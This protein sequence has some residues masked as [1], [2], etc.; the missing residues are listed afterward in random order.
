[1][2]LQVSYPCLIFSEESTRSEIVARGG[3]N[4]AQSPQADYTEQIFLP[5]LRDRF[6]LETE[7]TIRKHGYYPRG[8]GEVCLRIPPIRGPIPAVRLTERG[9]VKAITGK[10]FSA[11]LPRRWAEEIRDA[12]VAKL[13][14][15]GIDPDIIK[16]S[17]VRERYEDVVGKGTG[18]I[19]W[20][21]TENSCR[22]GGS[23]TGI[24][25]SDL[26]QL[27]TDAADELIRNLAHG[28]CVDEYLQVR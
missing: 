17:A 14:A 26:A 4:A 20:A 12:A 24:G 6:G 5:F 25:G 3:T 16:I 21:E 2:L 22:L 10:A 9:A 7:F 1:M 18:I 19:L 15:S 28:G 11:V 8:G 23:T 13:V 27:G